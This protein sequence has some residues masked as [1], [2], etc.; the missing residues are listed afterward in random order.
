MTNTELK[1]NN[2]HFSRGTRWLIVPFLLCLLLPICS[3]A[4]ISPPETKEKVTQV[5]FKSS[6]VNLLPAMNLAGDNL[7]NMLNPDRNYL[8]YWEQIVDE[9]YGSTMGFGWPAHDLGRWWDAMLRLQAA[10]GYSIPAP[11][12]K[13]M[14]DNLKRFFN[15]SNH[16]MMSPAG[17]VGDNFELHSLREGMLALNALVRYRTN[18]W[19]RQEGHLMAQSLLEKINF[20]DGTW[21][22]DLLDRGGRDPKLQ[23]AWATGENPIKSHGRLLEALVWFYEATHD[24]VVLDLTTRLAEYHFSNSTHADGTFN[25]TSKADHTHSYL[26][27]LRGLLLFG[28]LTGNQAYIDRVNATLRNYVLKDIIKPSGFM[29]HDLNTD[30][31]GETTSPGDVAQLALWL[32]ARHGQTDLWDVAERIVRARIIPSQITST[33]PLTPITSGDD[34]SVNLDKRLIGAIGG[35]HVQPHG[36]KRSTFDVTAADLHTLVDVYEHVATNSAGVLR[37][38]LHFTYED[39]SVRL[40]SVYSNLIGKF[41]VEPKQAATLLVRIPRWTPQ[42]RLRLSVNGTATA[43]RMADADYLDAGSVKPGDKVVLEYVLP[44][45]TTTEKEQGITYTF[46]WRGDDV[47]GVKASNPIYPFYPE[48]PNID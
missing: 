25:P 30:G 36:Y 23:P 9:N 8:P 5:K 47:L 40:T 44:L 21:K 29:A 7:M 45:F 14:L 42:D 35:M 1:K 31:N 12:E 17:S 32:A 16:I 11:I 19:A 3:T 33:P 4:Q 10:T 37:V 48:F 28:E 18:E 41:T 6:T 46:L 24:P 2:T 20:D 38:N 15:N 13:A 43:V 39:A 22:L 34:R 27:T 26:G